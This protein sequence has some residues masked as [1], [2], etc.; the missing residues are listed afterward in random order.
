MGSNFDEQLC[1]AVLKS[2]F[3][4]GIALGNNFEMQLQEIIFGSNF[5]GFWKIALKNHFGNQISSI[6]TLEQP[7]WRCFGQKKSGNNFGKSVWG[8]ILI[9]FPANFNE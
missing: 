7:F 2:S 6:I 9:N 3:E 5:G 4:W 8:K 1:T